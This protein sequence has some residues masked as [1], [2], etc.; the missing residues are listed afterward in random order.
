MINLSLGY[1]A[2]YVVLIGIASFIESPVG[3]GLGVFQLNAL[4]R[5]GSLAAAAVVLLATRPPDT[6]SIPKPAPV[7]MR[8]RLARL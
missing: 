2:V 3:R 1:V 7:R 5:A 6:A 4:I 8:P